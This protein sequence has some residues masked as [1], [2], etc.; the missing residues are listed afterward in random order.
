MK[1]ADEETLSGDLDDDERGAECHSADVK[2]YITNDDNDC[3]NNES[4]EEVPMKVI[5]LAATN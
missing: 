1:G 2:E 4:K 5:K 3:D